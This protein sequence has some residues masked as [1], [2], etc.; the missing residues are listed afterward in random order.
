MTASR[1]VDRDCVTCGQRFNGRYRQ[2]YECRASDRICTDCGTAFHGIN[3]RCAECYRSDRQCVTCGKQFRSRYRECRTCRAAKVTRSP[4][5][6]PGC[7]NPKVPGQGSRLCQEHRDDAYQRTLRRLRTTACSMPGCDEPKRTGLNADGRHKPYRYCAGHSFESEQRD[8]ARTLHR[9]RERLF[10]ITHDDF[11][12]ML[13]AQGN[14]CAICGNGETSKRQR[15]L[16]VDHDHETGAVR[17]L[18]CNRCNPMLGYARDDV[19]V[20]QAVIDYLRRSR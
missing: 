17:G 10:G 6:M 1:P 14:V 19:A 7:S 8:S 20:L 16:N 11:L 2:C 4:C 15:S 18:L 3:A 9:K 13:E 12:A 5:Q